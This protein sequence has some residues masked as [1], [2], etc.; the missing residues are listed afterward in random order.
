M[1]KIQ[2][3][4]FCC[5]LFDIFLKF[6]TAY[7]A[8]GHLVS[9]RASIGMKYLKTHGFYIDMLTLLVLAREEF[10]ILSDYP[11]IDLLV[12]LKLEH[13]FTL[14]RKIEESLYLEKK[15]HM[16]LSLFKLMVNIL[17]LN[18][19]LACVWHYIGRTTEGNQNWISIAG[20][21]AAK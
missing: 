11:I 1:E 15:S 18:N 21:A 6:N 2:T 10:D 8:N 4:C 19:I 3:A 17:V 13:L 16:M 20:L 14:Y 5:L 9:E 12:L 7:Y